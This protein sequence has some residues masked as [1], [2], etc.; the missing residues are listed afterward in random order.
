MAASRRPEPRPSGLPVHF[1]LG[2][3]M[4]LTDVHGSERLVRFVEMIGSSSVLEFE[5]PPPRAR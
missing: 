3:A 1:K 4:R 5:P 2:K